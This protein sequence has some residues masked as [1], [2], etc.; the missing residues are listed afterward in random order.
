M[1]IGKRIKYILAFSKISQRTFATNLKMGES[2]VSRLLNDKRKPTT[3]EIDN[4]LKVLNVPYEC[5]MGKVP[6]FD[7]LLESCNGIDYV[8][9]ECLW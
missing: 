3:R 2:Q 5:L 7:K 9:L 4:I 8:T 6:L 1:T